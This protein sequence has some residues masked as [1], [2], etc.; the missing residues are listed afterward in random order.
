MRSNWTRI[1]AFGSAVQNL[2]N[3]SIRI[4]FDLIWTK[5]RESFKTEWFEDS[6]F[7][8]THFPASGAVDTLPVPEDLRYLLDLRFALP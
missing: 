3:A 6:I 1:E 4:K 2:P 5:L 8:L 7:L